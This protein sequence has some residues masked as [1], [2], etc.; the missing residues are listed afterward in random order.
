MSLVLQIGPGGVEETWLN[1]AREAVS[2]LSGRGELPPFRIELPA[3]PGFEGRPPAA[4]LDGLM[5]A[6]D[7]AIAEALDARRDGGFGGALLVGAGVG[8]L[9]A[10]ELR[11]RGGW[12]DLPLLLLAPGPGYLPA[13][14]PLG[15]LRRLW[16]GERLSADPALRKQLFGGLQRCGAIPALREAWPARLEA[17]ARSLAENPGAG[18]HVAVCWGGRDALTQPAFE[19]WIR[20][21]LRAPERRAPDWGHLPFL[22][23]PEG[24]AR[25]LAALLDAPP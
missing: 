4:H 17:L 6:A 2:R 23:A 5:D 7:E 1:P 8:G 15:G 13:P 22:E 20:E 12:W 16:D 19:A 10:L 24:W 21:R 11:A 18:E 25:A 14:G 9:L 3:L